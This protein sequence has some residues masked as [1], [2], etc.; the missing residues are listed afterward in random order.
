[1]KQP[2]AKTLTLLPRNSPRKKLLVRTVAGPAIGFGHL[3]RTL[4]L[5]G[6][7]RRWAQ[8]L[9]LLDS[10]DLWSQEQ[11]M[12]G[13]FNYQCFDAR[14]PWHG[15]KAAA[16]LLIDTRQNAGLRRL[17][18]E[19]RVRGI[20][21]VSIHDLGLAPIASDIAIDGSILPAT[22]NF[23]QHAATCLTGMGYFVLEDSCEQLHRE[24]KT[25]RRRIQKVVINLGGGDGSRFFRTVLKGLRSAD[26][27][28]EVIGLPGF[29][30]WGQETVTRTSWDPLRFRWLSRKEDVAKLMFAADLVISAG[31]CAAYEALC[32]G[33]PL[34]A[35]SVDHYQAAT[36]AALADAGACI[37][38]GLGAQLRSGDVRRRFAELDLNP[39][40]RRRL[41]AHGRRLVDGGGAQRVARILRSILSGKTQDNNN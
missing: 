34:C 36:V 29:C 23:R 7:L 1:M 15:L 24:S 6:K 19:A 33:A 4:I 37:D 35:L 26:T 2:G 5:A 40:L 28:L 31:G 39:D 41:S 16:G 8:P 10:D 22:D 12:A 32:V 11:V 17:V 9:F 30:S 38:L 21:V 18:A 25:I 27:P 3:R 13:D 14:K 20:P